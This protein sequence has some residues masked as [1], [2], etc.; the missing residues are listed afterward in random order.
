[1]HSTSPAAVS[2]VGR[3]EFVTVGV[4]GEQF[5]AARF[6]RRQKDLDTGQ[7]ESAGGVEHLL[8]RHVCQRVGH[9][10]DLHDRP[11]S[12]SAIVTTRP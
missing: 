7:A 12:T 9:H 2:P 11:A 3:V 10:A 5:E 8:E 1:M 6:D 4:E